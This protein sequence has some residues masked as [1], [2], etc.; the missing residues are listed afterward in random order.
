[1]EKIKDGKLERLPIKNIVE[2]YFQF[3]QF[4]KSKIIKKS[5]K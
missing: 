1:M 3:L 5:C 4:V 2:N